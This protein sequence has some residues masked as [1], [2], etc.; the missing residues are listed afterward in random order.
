[1]KFH[2]LELIK[3]LTS[4]QIK[5]IK[6]NWIT[7]IEE[8]IAISNIPK[9]FEGLRQLIEVTEDKLKEIIKEALSI[10][11]IEE[12]K[13][14]I[15]EARPGP[16]GLIFSQEDKRKIEEIMKKWSIRRNEVGR[17]SS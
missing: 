16:L 12:K 13:F 10:I 1:M 2:P 14:Q 7:S 11:Q 8:L 5:R 15:S 6:E 4:E 17:N 3:S 9:G